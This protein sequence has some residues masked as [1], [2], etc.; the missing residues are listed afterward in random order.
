MSY[1]KYK[2]QC[3]ECRAWVKVCA[4]DASA[5]TLA[6]QRQEAYL[7][8]IHDPAH[9]SQAE[10]VIAVPTGHVVERHCRGAM[11]PPLQMVSLN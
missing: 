5:V 8:G 10:E 9:E 7:C 4:I 2:G 6:P 3:P 1:V 11:R